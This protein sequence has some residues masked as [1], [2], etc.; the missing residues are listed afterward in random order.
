MQSPDVPIQDIAELERLASLAL[1]AAKAKQYELFVE[2]YE[3]QEAG[4]RAL[5]QQMK[6]EDNSLPPAT[7]ENWLRVVRLREETQTQLVAWLDD[8]KSELAVISQNSRLF[9]TY[10]R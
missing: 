4:L 9:K 3:R 8:V 6:T 5:L 1:G 2:L 10:F 7:R